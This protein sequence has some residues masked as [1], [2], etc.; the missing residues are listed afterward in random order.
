MSFGS[1]KK[2]ARGERMLAS[3]LTEAGFPARRA[4]QYNGAQS[5]DIICP[6]LARWHWESKFAEQL[7]FRD[8]LAQAEGDCKG[9][10]WI[11][12]WKRK[13]GPWLAVMKLDD[14]IELI[15]DRL[16]PQ[17]NLPQP[18]AS[19]DAET[20][21]AAS[22]QTE[23]N[24]KET[25]DMKIDELYPS[26]WLKAADV[27]RP[28]LATIKNVTVE[29][30]SEGEDKP[31][32]NFLGDLKPMVLNRTNST[33]VAELY[34]EDTDHWTGKP[35]VLFSTKVQFQSKLVDAIRVRAPKQQA[36]APAKSAPAPARGSKVA[37]ELPAESD[38]VPF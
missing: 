2:G 3:I 17:N 7:R 20:M 5:A 32:L 36:A 8:W 38:D 28:V 35:V 31:I 29:E 14:L 4:Q 26:R 23:P 21:L 34:G 37:E 16:P 27:T 33:T 18:A 6:A 22:T 9:K 19:G 10:P 25:T 24:R 13:F 1:K 11:I 12:A 30:V 15:R